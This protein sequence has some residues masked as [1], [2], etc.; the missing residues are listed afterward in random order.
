M[1][2][3]KKDSGQICGW[4]AS[5]FGGVE[6]GDKRLKDR[7]IVLADRLSESPDSPAINFDRSVTLPLLS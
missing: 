3:A 6:L 5:E 4:A 2:L 1:E 7:V